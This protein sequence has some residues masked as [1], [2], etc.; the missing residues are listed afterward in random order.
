MTDAGASVGQVGAGFARV[1]WR[2]LVLLLVVG[3]VLE[4]ALRSRG[5]PPQNLERVGFSPTVIDRWTEWAMRPN[6]RINEYAV[7]NAYGL[8]EDR[9]VNLQKAPGVRRVA[10]IGSSVTWGLSEALEN[11]IPRSV[12]R[13]LKQAGCAAE[14]LNFGGQGYNILNASAYVQTKMHQFNPDAVV[15]MM[16]LQMGLPRFPRPNPL[17]DESAVVRRLGFFEGLWKHST[18]YSVV[19]RAI[20][21][22]RWSRG[23]FVE[24]LGLPAGPNTAAEARIAAREPAVLG[25]HALSEIWRWT[26]AKAAALAEPLRARETANPATMAEAAPAPAAPEERTARQY[27]QRRERELRAVVAA[28]SAFSR[29]FGI[30]LYFVTPYGP[31]FHA[32]DAQLARFSLHI[33]AEAVP[34]YGS[35]AAATRREAELQSQVV[36]RAAE[37]NGARV[38]DMLPASRE[39]TMETGDF[40]NDGIHFSSLGY[41]H[42]ASVIAARLQRDGLCG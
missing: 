19:L 40:S 36:A 33:I 10:V 35:L 17:S 26:T 34:L 42:V 32:T 6:V 9:E 7:T 41:R 13:K 37:R 12:E 38:I 39:A 16:D 29:E 20:D 18:E 2:V 27:E 23:L 14:V 25:R 30:P 3:I 11:T 28:A 31:Y 24:R 8:H 21:D 5:F 22:V 15:V 4:T 1:A